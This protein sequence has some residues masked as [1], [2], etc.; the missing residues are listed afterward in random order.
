[1]VRS[2]SYAHIMKYLGHY[3][4]FW[5]IYLTLQCLDRVSDWMM[6]M[7]VVVVVFAKCKDHD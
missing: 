6:V 1:M 3:I 2:H 7:G 4:N 5:L